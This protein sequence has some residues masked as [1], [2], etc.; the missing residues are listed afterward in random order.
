MNGNEYWL[1]GIK[2]SEKLRSIA[3]L[4]GKCAIQGNGICYIGKD[5]QESNGGKGTYGKVKRLKW[6]EESKE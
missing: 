5:G 6:R 3:K 1:G 4:M 2:L